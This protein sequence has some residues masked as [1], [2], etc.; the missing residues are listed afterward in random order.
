MTKILW[1]AILFLEQAL[2]SVF[3]FKKIGDM[4]MAQVVKNNNEYKYKHDEVTKK[5]KN[6]FN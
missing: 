2:W 1:C 6:K 3:Y 5:N 4:Y